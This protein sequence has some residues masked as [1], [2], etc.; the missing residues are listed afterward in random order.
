MPYLMQ[1][2]SSTT[3]EL[4]TWVT[5]DADF[6][7]VDFPGPGSP[8]HI[9]ISSRPAS[10]DAEVEVAD[11]IAKSAG[12]TIDR[13][14]G[15]RGRPI[16][17]TAPTDGQAYV[18]DVGGDQHKPGWPRRPGEFNVL[19]Y[20]AIAYESLADARAG[21]DSSAA[22]Q[23][24]FDALGD[25]ADFSRGGALH[26][27]TGYYRISA[28]L[29][30]R[31]TG[32]IRGQGAS[33][34]YGR[35]VLAFDD[36][37]NITIDSYAD[38]EDGGRA[39]SL[40]V[41]GV[42]FYGPQTKTTP[43][44]AG[45]VVRSTAHFLHCTFIYFHGRGMEVDGSIDPLVYN[46]NFGSMDTCWFENNTSDG[47]Y[48]HGGNGNTWLVTQCI[49]SNNGTEQAAA[50]VWQVDVSAGP[51]FVDLTTDFNDVGTSDVA[52][53]PSAEAIGDYVAIGFATKFTKLTIDNS[54][55]TPGVGGVVAWEYWN[56]STWTALPSI[57]DDAA[58]F[59]AAQ[60]SNWLVAW[61]EPDDWAT[62]TLNG[63]GPYYWVRARVTTVYST[64]PTIDQGWLH[65]GAGVNDSSFLGCTYVNPLTEGNATAFR[66]E[67]GA[68][69]TTILNPYAEL[70]QGPC[71]LDQLVV[72]LGGGLFGVGYGTHAHLHITNA[73]DVSPLHV[74]NKRGTVD[75]HSHLGFDDTSLVAFRWS[76]SD[77]TYQHQLYYEPAA[78]SQRW[79]CRSLSSGNV[80][81][82]LTSE[83]H[84]AGAGWT[85]F[86]NGILLT[87]NQRLLTYATAVP[88]G[89]CVRA[90]GNWLQGDF[91]L[92]TGGF[93]GYP[94]GW[95]CVGDGNP[96]SWSVAG[97]AQSSFY[98]WT[99]Q[100]IRVWADSGATEGTA[101]AAKIQE[102]ARRRQIQTTTASA[103]Q[104][105][106]DGGS[107][108]GV[109]LTLPDNA[110]THLA[111]LLLVKKNGAAAGG[112]IK[113]EAD[114]YRDAAG[115]PTIIGSPSITYNLTGS[116]LDG[117][118]A[119]LNVNGNKVEVRV[120]PESADT[121]DW[122]IVR[123]QTEGS[124]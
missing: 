51:A 114:Y 89:A 99:P 21:T 115:A 83:G 94:I 91:V 69:R 67:G 47:F 57:R 76:S 50:K 123:T 55:A 70:D 95:Y 48:I 80:A 116:T 11:D 19:D 16:T 73:E 29:F 27:P 71:R 37:K 8:E 2:V 86:P 105:I 44:T 5:A 96:G 30:V 1:A 61:E 122:R 15:L 66:I 110:I 45:V 17:A 100:A 32:E 18:Y 92:N 68:N 34:R 25:L 120:S 35:S 9:A 72:V 75:V 81:Y 59:T 12:S 104:V 20:G 79:D 3:G 82:S 118:T 121:L 39:D 56:G 78:G 106:E 28:N 87:G 49:F 102:R 33:G 31:R 14:Q 84:F 63:A 42:T 113:I 36:G 97:F 107:F 62:L 77:A 109:D 111:V 41:E 24:A 23:A 26:I 4:V 60:A 108:G 124:S 22:F 43:I 7:G 117:T 90:S 88:S 119:D 46:A 53:F 85:L 98:Q 64:N 13:V 65:A 38:S 52:P 101:A 54:G 40:R 103:N 93:L 6:A 112:S 74:I 10:A 58:G